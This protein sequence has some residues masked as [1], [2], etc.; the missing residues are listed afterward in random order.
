MLDHSCVI[1]WCGN[2]AHMMAYPISDTHTSWAYV[3]SIVTSD[4]INFSTLNSITTRE[5]EEARESWRTIDRQELET[6][7][8]TPIAQWEFGVSELIETTEKLVKVCRTR[9][10]FQ[11]KPQFPS[12]LACMIDL[13]YIPGTKGVS[14]SW[15]M[16]HTQPLPYVSMVTILQTFLMQ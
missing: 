12:S 10:R 7:K 16:Q 9:R 3:S 6:I 11:F 13:S 4:P 8:K 1:N 15:G 14:C 5:G 2:G